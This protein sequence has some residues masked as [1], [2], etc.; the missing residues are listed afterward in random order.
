MDLKSREAFFTDFF[1]KPTFNTDEFLSQCTQ[2]ADLLSVRKE[3][4]EYGSKLYSMMVDILKT[5]TEGIINLAENLTHLS[6]TIDE[7]SSPVSQLCEE[8]RSLHHA[9]TSAKMNFKDHLNKVE[10]LAYEKNVLNLKIA[11]SSSSAYIDQVILSWERDPDVTTLERAINEYSFQHLHLKELQL[12]AVVLG[13]SG[14]NLVVRLVQLVNGVFLTALKGQDEVLIVRCLRMY[15][16][17]VKQ[18]AAN[19]CVRKHVAAPG[20]RSIFTQK[21]LDRHGQDVNELYK[22]AVKFLNEEFGVLLGVLQRNADLRGFKFILDSYWVEVDEQIRNNLPN[23]TAPGNPE[24]FQRRYKDTWNFLHQILRMSGDITTNQS[25]HDHMKRFNLP[26]YFEIVLQQ[27]SIKFETEMLIEPTTFS[28]AEWKQLASGHESFK[29]KLTEA[30][31]IGIQQCFNESVYLTH[32]VDQF[33][34]LMMLLVSRYMTWF[35]GFL[36][37]WRGAAS[38]NTEELEKFIVYALMDIKKLVTL[39]SPPTNITDYD[40]TIFNLVTPDVRPYLSKILNIHVT[41][42]NKLCLKLQKHLIHFKVQQ[43]AVHLQQVTSIPRLYRR[44]NR[45]VPQK[46]S[47]YVLVTVSPII[48]LHDN[49]RTLM[50]EGIVN[51]LD[52]IIGELAA[53]YLSLVQEVLHSVCK[54]EES[55]RRLKNRSLNFV[56]E[57]AGQTS[58]DATSDEA[59]IREQIKIDV[60]YFVNELNPFSL[61]GSQQMLQRLLKESSRLDHK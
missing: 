23:I 29:L 37:K 18:D 40:S 32:L 43:G 59:K 2:K 57:S 12:D 52:G 10:S 9:I 3:L 13:N 54:T 14:E 19:E 36:N 27:I 41:M 49:F 58:G 46:P 28:A 35:N 42:L 45:N 6:V 11:I 20:L 34:K 44:T 16:N 48:K 25:L 4:K 7:L 61:A 53:Q 22:Q 31:W 39:L 47:N 51:V 1:F 17:L 55:L 33:F 38:S 5:E 26:V 50:E 21:N 60:G 15:V 8:I 30:L 24:L 56:D